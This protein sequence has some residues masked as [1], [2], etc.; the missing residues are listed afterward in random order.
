MVL[1]EIQKWVVE[2]PIISS[3]LITIF[4]SLSMVSIYNK[5]FDIHLTEDTMFLFIII[6]FYFWVGFLTRAR[7]E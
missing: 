6:N 3:I 4:L 5:S 1:K 2:N 7:E